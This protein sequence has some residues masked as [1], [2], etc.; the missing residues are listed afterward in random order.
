M[1]LFLTCTQNCSTFKMERT[2]FLVF[3]VILHLSVVLLQIIINIKI[4]CCVLR[5]GVYCV[6]AED[7]RTRIKCQSIISLFIVILEF[8]SNWTTINLSF[9]IA[10]PKSNKTRLTG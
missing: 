4:T 6:L 7:I 9:T 1:Q 3:L 2:M 10:K 8:G 5:I